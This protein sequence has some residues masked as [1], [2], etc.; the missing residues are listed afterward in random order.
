MSRKAG[1]SI[2]PAMSLNFEEEECIFKDEKLPEL[3]PA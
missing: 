3:L 1:A 2:F